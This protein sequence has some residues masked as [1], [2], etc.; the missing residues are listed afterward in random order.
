[1]AYPSR[2]S[3]GQVA[4]PFG[5]GGQ[6]KKKP[7]TTKESGSSTSFLRATGVLTSG[8]A[9]GVIGGL[10]GVFLDRTPI[11]SNGAR[12][13]EG[14][15]FDQRF[16]LKDQTPMNGFTDSVS[17]ETSVGLEVKANVPITRSFTNPNVDSV[18]VRV[19]LQLQEFPDEG[20][21]KALRI[22]FRILIRQGLG[23]FVEVHRQSMKER[24]ASQVEFEY[25]FPLDNQ[26]G[27]V[28]NF[29]IRVERI[30]P[31]DSNTLRYQRILTFRAFGESIN[32]GLVYPY[33]AMVGLQ[34]EA[35]QFAS[36][37]Q[38]SFLAGGR[39]I[40]IPS[41]GTVT[42]DRGIDY[43]GPWNGQFIEA[44]IACADP[45]WIFYDMCINNIYGFGRYIEQS[46]LDK[47]SFYA[48]SQ[49][50]NEY[51]QIGVA[52]PGSYTETPIM[53]RRYR[54]N[55]VINGLPDAWEI[56]DA[57]RSIFRGMLFWHA[58]ATVIE[59]DRPTPVSM[60]LGHADVVEGSFSY[61]SSPQRAIHT[62]AHVSWNNPDNFYE[63]EIEPVTDH[64]GLRRY[65]RN[66]LRTSAF[67]CT[68]RTQ[69]HRLGWAYLISDRLERETVRFRVRGKGAYLL[70]GKVVE[71]MDVID[72]VLRYSGIIESA[73]LGTV[74][75]DRA[76]TLQA[77]ETYR[78][79][80]T[81]PDG[82]ISRRT[83]TSAPGD[84]KILTL[85]QPLSAVPLTRS[86]W[87][88]SS[89]TIGPAAFR[90]VSIIP[91]PE[92]D[93]L[94]FEV[95]ATEYSDEKFSVI[96][97][98]YYVPPAP[99]PVKP[100]PNP[101]PP[102]N[103]AGQID[104]SPLGFLLSATWTRPE[105]SDAVIGYLARYR[106]IGGEWSDPE[107]EVSYTSVSWDITADGGYEI[108]IAS[109][110]YNGKTSA[111]VP[112]TIEAPVNFSYDFSSQ[113]SIYSVV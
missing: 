104:Q 25:E 6:K 106:P 85:D 62:V 100:P 37:P 89:A 101:S 26:G 65:G 94:T 87:Q 51:L 30:T 29:Q 5:A 95:T 15:A 56:L 59:A 68:S 16:G 73:T 86:S 38:I 27:T 4:V 10:A 40:L 42:S 67:G 63:S 93:L 11:E 103:V 76:V 1:M 107:T 17:V 83:I 66:L 80:L 41:N 46:A 21:Y 44:P 35:S 72:S 2:A 71:L 112:A 113:Y 14:V 99:A 54:C 47:W 82:T 64:V 70:P 105:N 39:L 58:G 88:L 45:A 78:I 108:E 22:E 31:Q 111:W 96:D 20:G 18:R 69:A 74:T 84:R 8:P 43:V 52:N 28:S 102:T 33:L 34:F 32:K 48:L 77:G 9:E 50:C 110:D 81:M 60:I 75:L 49:Y 13:F 7:K 91:V 109:L 92:V 97:T 90:V 3:R 61:V 55:V 57:I 98:D 23:G 79:A 12:N 36:L 19:G 53:E 24:F